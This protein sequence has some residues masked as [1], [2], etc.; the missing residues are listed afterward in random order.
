MELEQNEIILRESNC[1]CRV[2][3][4]D[5]YNWNKGKCYLT[6]MRIIF[7]SNLENLERREAIIALENIYAINA[8]PNDFI[9]TTISILLTNNSIIDLDFR[10]NRS[11]WIKNIGLAIKETK[12]E[13]DKHWELNQ[14]LNIQT[15][16]RESEWAVAKKSL[17]IQIFFLFATILALNL[18][19][20]YSDLPLS[21]TVSICYL[22]LSTY[23]WVKTYKK[24]KFSQKVQVTGLLISAVSFS[25]LFSYNTFVTNS[26][27]NILLILTIGTIP[28]FLASYI[29]KHFAK[30]EKAVNLLNEDIAIK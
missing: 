25:T 3:S 27:F 13:K 16:D 10:K 24:G 2:D 12:K 20:K 9:H 23:L 8:K 11:D 21:V 19:R 30:K 5:P 28:I 6:N 14:I 18:L 4:S 17:F 15:F 7:E 22:M 1:K 26:N 29:A